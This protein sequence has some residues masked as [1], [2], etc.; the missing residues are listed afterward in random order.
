MAFLPGVTFRSLAAR[1]T[2]HHSPRATIC[3]YSVAGPT[4]AAKQLPNSSASTIPLGT[5]VQTDE[6]CPSY[7]SPGPKSLIRAFAFSWQRRIIY[8]SLRFWRPTFILGRLFWAVL[9]TTVSYYAQLLFALPRLSS[10]Y[11][12]QQFHF[13]P[14]VVSPDSRQ[15]SRQ[16]CADLRQAHNRRLHGPSCIVV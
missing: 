4:L 10:A 12:H 9:F 14:M 11:R 2:H 8:Q 15:W 7:F 6:K 1:I 3:R 16:P 13:L 5:F